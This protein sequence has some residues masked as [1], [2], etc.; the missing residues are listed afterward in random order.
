MCSPVSKSISQKER[1]KN[2]CVVIL[3]IIVLT[4]SNFFDKRSQTQT[5]NNAAETEYLRNYCK[6]ENCL[7]TKDFLVMFDLHHGNHA[8][9]IRLHE[10]MVCDMS[11]QGVPKHLAK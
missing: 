8:A 7:A 4:Q 3:P 2:E 1:D 10:K 11:I 5:L 9:A 6:K